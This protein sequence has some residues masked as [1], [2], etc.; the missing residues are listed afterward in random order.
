MGGTVSLT[1]KLFNAIDVDHSG[2]LTKDELK[3]WFGHRIPNLDE[4]DKA[5]MLY[6]ISD[7]K[8]LDRVSFA[9]FFKSWT[10]NQLESASVTICR[11]HDMTKE[12]QDILEEHDEDE[13]KMLERGEIAVL[14]N[15]NQ[16]KGN[17]QKQLRGLFRLLDSD[18][19]GF[20]PLKDISDEFLRHHKLANKSGCICPCLLCDFLYDEI[21]KRAHTP[22]C[23][24]CGSKLKFMERSQVSN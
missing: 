24:G 20:V 17:Y 3:D 4:G 7:G 6:S 23:C 12:V 22:A 18:A 14:L 2:T 16:R 15:P 19:T 8:E 10:G 11:L 1:D 21:F 9:Q 5:Q 13:D